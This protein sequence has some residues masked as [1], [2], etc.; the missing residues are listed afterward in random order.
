[1]TFVLDSP[2]TVGETVVAAVTRNTISKNISDRHIAVTG[3]KHPVALLVKSDDLLIALNPSGA[4]MTLD[5][6]EKLCPGMVSRFETA[7]ER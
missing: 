4:S 1:M 6:V 5:D 2:V 7:T 3:A